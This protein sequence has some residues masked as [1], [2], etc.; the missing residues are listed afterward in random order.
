[1][2]VRARHARVLHVADHQDLQPREVR[3]LG[4]ADGH[5]VQ[6]ALG[7]VRAAAIAGI[8]QRGALARFGRQRGDRTV[9]GV[10]DDEAAHAHR[11]QVAQRVA[12]RLA[13]AR[14]RGG[15]VEVQHVRTQPLRGD[16]ERA[17]GARGRLEEQRA[18]G[19][20]V[21][22]L[23][24]W[25]AAQRRVADL[26]GAVDQA[27]QGLARQAV[28]G[29][30][31]AQASIGIELW[32]HGVSSGKSQ[33]NWVASCGAASQR[34][35]MTAAATASSATASRRRLRPSARSRAKRCAASTEL[36]RSSTSTTGRW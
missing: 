6:Q 30:Q 36:V 7:R 9:L 3:A 21:Q 20:A 26:A 4:L 18:H 31:V 17:A 22:R 35:M 13:L 27:A 14:G 34:S 28:E 11:L 32:G 5:H 12:R 2:Q 1:M 15:R 33:V 8:D 24:T 29:Q 25:R 23:P 10:A 19:G 16:V